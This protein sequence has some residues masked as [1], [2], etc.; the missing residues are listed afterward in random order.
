MQTQSSFNIDN[1]NTLLQKEIQSK[2][3][4]IFGIVLASC[5]SLIIIF[6]PQRNYVPNYILN[7]RNSYDSQDQLCIYQFS[8]QPT[9]CTQIQ[10]NITQVTIDVNDNNSTHILI[11]D[12]LYVSN[13][14][15]IQMVLL[16]FQIYIQ[17]VQRQLKN[18]FSIQN[19]RKYCG[20]YNEIQIRQ[21]QWINIK[22]LISKWFRWSFA[23]RLVLKYLT[24]RSKC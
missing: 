8:T 12:E 23:L 24:L 21:N 1:P 4:L 17:Q 14:I 22:N 20:T 11:L 10:A 9:N 7:Q 16:F 19:L 13:I 18:L 5:L 3:Q 15:T 6:T 2:N